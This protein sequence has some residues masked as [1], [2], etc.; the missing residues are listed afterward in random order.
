MET[1]D[2]AT[3]YQDFSLETDQTRNSNWWK[4]RKILNQNKYCTTC[5]ITE[6]DA[7]LFFH[8]T[9]ARAFWFSANPPMCSSILSIEQDEVQ[10]ILPM[11]VNQ[12]TSDEQMQ[13]IITTLWYMWKARNDKRFNNKSWMVWQVHNAVATDISATLLTKAQE[14][15]QGTMEQQ[16]HQDDDLSTHNLQPTNEGMNLSNVGTKNTRLQ[17]YCNS[18]QM[19]K[20]QGTR[21]NTAHPHKQ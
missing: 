10:E 4:G 15:D 5:N 12:Q 13:V 1:Q 9:F 20:T 18:A 11:L 21:G 8:C 17:N 19:M 16:P 7:H 6:N 3:L 2:T 14:E